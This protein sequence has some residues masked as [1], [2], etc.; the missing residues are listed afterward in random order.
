MKLSP[1][2]VALLV[3][4]AT[5]LV[6]GSLIL[7]AALPAH[8]TGGDSQITS[9]PSMMSDTCTKEGMDQCEYSCMMPGGILDLNCY[10]DCIYSIC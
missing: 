4:G 7:P 2:L 8:S 9:G 1:V 6:Q 5:L 3:L 10:E